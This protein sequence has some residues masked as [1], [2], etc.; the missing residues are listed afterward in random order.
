MYKAVKI[1]FSLVT[2][3]IKILLYLTA[4]YLGT[5]FLWVVLVLCAMTVQL[6]LS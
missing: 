5:R 3:K 2:Y 4:L 1:C 6:N